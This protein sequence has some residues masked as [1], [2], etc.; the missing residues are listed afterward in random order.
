VS[1]IPSQAP[2]VYS[3]DI[4]D[5]FEEHP[6]LRPIQQQDFHNIQ[7]GRQ[8][9]PPI[10]TT[11]PYTPLTPTFILGNSYNSFSASSNYTDR[12][13]RLQIPRDFIPAYG[14]LNESNNGPM[15][16]HV[17][18]AHSP[19][20]SIQLAPLPK[21]TAFTSPNHNYPSGPAPPGFDA[22]YVSD[23]RQQ[24]QTYNYP[25]YSNVHQPNVNYAIHNQEFERQQHNHRQQQQHQQ[26]RQCITSPFRA[27]YN[28][29][30][31]SA[32]VL[33]G[34]S[35]FP[36]PFPDFHDLYSLGQPRSSGTSAR[37][38][39]DGIQSFAAVSSTGYG[40]DLRPMEMGYLEQPE[41]ILGSSRVGAVNKTSDRRASKKRKSVIG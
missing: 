22:K 3:N 9:L 39:Q 14:P 6:T 27:S 24:F 26:G 2:S 19:A 40:G 1:N 7:S 17:L 38:Q 4:R 16:P 8:T 15:R 5:S 23:E 18:P 41:Q 10:S 33:P 35:T 20:S 12:D 11:I 25:N 30:S 36:S 29:Q 31:S 32:P 28:T 37:A 13:F 21:H 34:F